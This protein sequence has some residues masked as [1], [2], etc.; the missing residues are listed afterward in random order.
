MRGK[1][2]KKIR[3]AAQAKSVGHEYS[4]YEKESLS[5]PRT[6]R[7]VQGCERA[8]YQALKQAALSKKRA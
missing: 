7:L 6:I 3:K 2:A 1:L 8:R 5:N 4:I